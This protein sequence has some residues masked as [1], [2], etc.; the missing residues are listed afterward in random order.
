[1]GRVAGIHGEGIYWIYWL[2]EF[3]LKLMIWPLVQIPWGPRSVWWMGYLVDEGTLA[4][5][6]FN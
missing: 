2:C 3:L 5:E 1:M 6:T 4:M